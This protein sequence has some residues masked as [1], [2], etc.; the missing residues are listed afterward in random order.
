MKKI[1]C[2]VITFIMLFANC[3]FASTYTDVEENS[4]FGITLSF[5]S[6]MGII[7]GYD[8]DTFRGEEKLTRAEFSVIVARMLKLPEQID[9]SNVYYV[10]VPASH[11]A[12]GAIEQLTEKK[13]FSGKGNGYFGINDSVTVWE[14]VAVFLR[15]CGYEKLAE[16]R[17]GFPTGYN[18]VSQETKLLNGLNINSSYISRRD[19]AILIE[20]AFNLGM[21]SVQTVSDKS[22]VGY[23]VSDDTILSLYWNMYQTKGTVT[24]ANGTNLNNTPCLKDS[25]IINDYE[26]KVSENDDYIDYLGTYVKAYFTKDAETETKTLYFIAMSDSNNKITKI[27]YDDFLRFDENYTVSYYDGDKIKT[28]KIINGVKVICN[29]VNIPSFE[30]KKL[31]LKYGYIELIKTNSSNVTVIK[32]WDYETC[33]VTSVDSEKK[34]VYAKGLK[35]PVDLGDRNEICFIKNRSM[36]NIDFSKISNKTVL[37]VAR[38]EKT[39]RVF[40]SEETL[41]TNIESINLNENEIIAGGIKYSV[42]PSYKDT[43]SKEFGFENLKIYIDIL[44]N[45]AYAEE[46]KNDG[47]LFAY[48]IDGGN[49][50]ESFD[51]RIVLKLFMQSGKVQTLYVDSKADIDGQAYDSQKEALGNYAPQLIRVK[52]NKNNEIIYIDTAGPKNGENEYTL[53]EQI[54]YGKYNYKWNGSIGGKGVMNDSTIIFVVPED[55]DIKKAKDDKFSIA[56]K[57]NMIVDNKDTYIGSYKTT[58]KVGYEQVCLMKKDMGGTKSWAKGWTVVSKVSQ[59]VNSEGE[60]VTKLITYTNGIRKEILAR[61]ESESKITPTAFKEGAVL[62]L[63]TNPSGEITSF[64]ECRVICTPDHITN[65]NDILHADD[66]SEKLESGELLE[67]LKEASPFDTVNQEATNAQDDIDSNE[68]YTFGYPYEAEDGILRVSYYYGKD[69]SEAYEMKGTYTLVDTTNPDNMVSSCTINDI[70]TSDIYGENCDKILI[71]V[72][73]SSIISVVVFR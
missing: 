62:Y 51:D 53:S 16:A 11:W 20:N 69:W 34:Y 49:A 21:Y 24:A 29:G 35:E 50:T 40:L 47:T 6:E 68:K 57:A 19:M 17:G 54:P 66:F 63:A 32:I 25:I 55:K 36:E 56:K 61:P 7:N 43:F 12:A 22:G 1:V 4:D 65:I 8:D 58:P 52:L 10:D 27:S 70:H 14:A 33:F 59:A 60:A 41:E 30:L 28:E 5:L 18:R 42:V 31:G 46:S 64:S 38:Y 2:L 23:E 73:N 71:Q 45:I 67:L 37:T 9:S 44:G 15:I 3:V 39:V 26:Y 72:K 48:L 13:Y